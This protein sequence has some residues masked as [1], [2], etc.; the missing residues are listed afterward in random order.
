MINIFI[1]NFFTKRH[2]PYTNGPSVLVVPEVNVGTLIM[3]TRTSVHVR[4]SH[5]FLRS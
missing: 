3:V 1:I 4:R 2:S 5:Q